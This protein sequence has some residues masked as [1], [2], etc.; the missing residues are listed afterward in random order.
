MKTVLGKY[1]EAKVFTDLVDE[2]SLEQVKMLLDQPFVEGQKVRFMPDI[3]AGAGCVVGTTMTVKD[4][5]CPNL[6]GVDI[7][8]GMLAA[9]IEDKDIEP[10]SAQ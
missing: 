6:I 9:K 4:K 1:N 3:H 5:I 7:G 8:C 2:K 10:Q